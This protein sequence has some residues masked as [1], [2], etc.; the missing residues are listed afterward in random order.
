MTA[1]CDRPAADSGGPHALPKTC[2][3]GRPHVLCICSL[4]SEQALLQTLLLARFVCWFFIFAFCC[5]SSALTQIHHLEFA[6]RSEN[7]TGV[8][9]AFSCLEQRRRCC[10]P[11][12]RTRWDE[13][14][15]ETRREV[16]TSRWNN[17]PQKILR[18]C[19][20]YVTFCGARRSS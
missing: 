16:S 20:N 11:L 17:L 13:N 2:F 18:K 19:E 14:R 1:N 9:M 12:N 7:A 5:H 3:P 15:G 6:P 4:K 8:Q 10:P